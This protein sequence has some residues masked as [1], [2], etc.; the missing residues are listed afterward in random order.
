MKHHSAFFS[1]GVRLGLSLTLQGT[2]LM[3]PA[4]TLQ[5]FAPLSAHAE[6][7]PQVVS[8]QAV[9][10]EGTS[11]V[12]AR[13]DAFRNAISQAVGVFVRS[14]TTVRDYVTQSDKVRTSSQGFIKSFKL[15]EE[16]T[17]PDGIVEAIYAIDVSTAPLKSDLKSVVGT[18]FSNVGHPTVAV[19]GWYNAGTRQ[20]KEAGSTAVAALN[21]ALI[22]RGYKVVDASE[23]E[24]LRKEDAA[25]R[26]VSESATPSNFEQV[27]RAIAQRLKADI[28]VTTFGSV[29]A[30][31][32]SVAT[33]M[34][35]TSTGQVFGS[36][37]GYGKATDASLASAKR[38]VDDA[39]TRSMDTVLN[40]LSNHWQNVLQN[41]QEYIV[42]FDGYR[43]GKE[44][45]TFKALLEQV[46]GITDVKQLSASASKA[47]FSLRGNGSPVELFD[48]VIELAEAAG[49]KFVNDEA[50]IRGS[51]A[52][53]L[54]K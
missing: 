10:G 28:Y 33:R 14:D 35:N 38:A 49:M 8:F 31:K 22:N 11:A 13:Q 19:V 36:E 21:R 18:E 5:T 6:T 43:N 7:I 51:R 15:I 24:R 53:F 20:D 54:L 16:N 39:I 37:T 34:Y 12:A 45:R 42:V 27:A 17:L 2:L 26:K 48:E 52:V 30:G 25:L 4:L 46:S 1:R 41:G 3:G 23:I 50:V 9:R 40:Q 29:G 47:E 32:A 44:R